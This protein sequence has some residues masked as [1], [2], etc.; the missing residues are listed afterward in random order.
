MYSVYVLYKRLS[1]SKRASA[2][3]CLMAFAWCATYIENRIPSQQKQCTLQSPGIVPIFTTKGMCTIVLLL[4]TNCR[5]L[6]RLLIPNYPV[7]TQGRFTQSLLFAHGYSA[8]VARPGFSTNIISPKYSARVIDPWCPKLFCL[9]YS[10][11]VVLPVWFTPSGI[12]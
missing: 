6:P 1:C 2:S 10:A 11:Q 3:S 5:S 9:S 7:K 8:R 12:C 4:N